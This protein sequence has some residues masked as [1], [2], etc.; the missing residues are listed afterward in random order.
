MS[1]SYYDL[2]RKYKQKYVELQNKIN[3]GGA[4][5][6]PS[7]AAS[8]PGGAASDPSGAA[9][10]PGGDD[11]NTMYKFI[12]K[13]EVPP[14]VTKYFRNIPTY[15]INLNLKQLTITSQKKQKILSNILAKPY[16]ID[17]TVSD[18]WSDH[19]L[20]YKN[21]NE[22]LY[23]SWN[24]LH[25]ESL[26]FGNRVNRNVL[27]VEG[28]SVSEVKN[29]MCANIIINKIREQNFKF[30]SLQECDPDIVMK[31]Y[32]LINDEDKSNYQIIYHPTNIVGN[33][34]DLEFGQPI[35]PSDKLLSPDSYALTKYGNSIILLKDSGCT[36]DSYF[37]VFSSTTT[38]IQ[39][40]KFNYIC[41]TNINETTM[42]VSLHI[43]GFE[44]YDFYNDLVKCMNEFIVDHKSYTIKKIILSGDFNNH[45]YY[46]GTANE[47]DCTETLTNINNDFIKK[48][49]F[50]IDEQIESSN[51]DH[52]LILTSKGL[53]RLTD[54]EKKDATISVAAR[55]VVARSVDVSSGADSTRVGSRDSDPGR[56]VTM[57]KSKGA[58]EDASGAPG[59]GKGL[60]RG[61]GSWMFGRDASGAAS[62]G[63]ESTR[64]GSRDPDPGMRIGMG[65]VKGSGSE[66]VFDWR[67]GIDRNASGAAEDISDA[68]R[69]GAM[70]RGKGR[71]GKGREG[72]G[73]EGK[74]REGKGR[75][76]F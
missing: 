17:D 45:T 29:T 64:F 28:I 44:I 23:Y 27:K 16:T 34:L 33:N 53:S 52:I 19:T 61:E 62:S 8:D 73:R 38:D 3:N 37:N 69:S 35:P 22:L 14:F 70:G 41:E 24:T 11:I 9:S 48:Y 68:A 15:E 4:A 54:K 30:I 59:Q 57:C 40:I 20:I 32:N 46:I 47:L 74:G 58:A 2:Y 21:N 49:N 13:Y 6:D 71:E 39:F 67:M 10:D 65:R 72:K 26:L 1:K 50:N 43:Q 60:G 36:Y 76:G 42:Y 5:S 51:I 63:A 12:K 56:R 55:S 75:E 25:I 7:G 31:V 18:N 66:G